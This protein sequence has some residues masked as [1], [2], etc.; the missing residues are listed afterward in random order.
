MSNGLPS[1][2]TL[3]SSRLKSTLFGLICLIFVLMGIWI[4]SDPEN[5]LM[6]WFTIAFFGLGLAIFIMQLIR[7]GRLTLDQNGFEQVILGRSLTCKWTEVSDFGV[8]K[9]KHN[10]FVSFSRQQDEGKM[11]AGVSKTLTGGH[12]GML[13]DSFGMKPKELAI[14]MNEYRDKALQRTG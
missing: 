9:V 14:L 5:A 2:L 7:P 11:L 3:T 12:S 1:T 10:K 8:L 4:L 6:G 13:G